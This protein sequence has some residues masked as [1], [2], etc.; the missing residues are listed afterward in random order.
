MPLGNVCEYICAH[1]CADL[2]PSMVT[3]KTPTKWSSRF[4]HAWCLLLS[5]RQHGIQG[6]IGALVLERFRFKS[7]LNHFL[8]VWPWARYLT[9]LSLIFLICAMG[10]L[11]LFSKTLRIGAGLVVQRLSLHVPL[12]WP[13]NRWLRSQV[14]TYALLVKLCGRRPTYKVE[15]D[16]HGC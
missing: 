4:F 13:G 9:C 16:G 8:T 14:W 5:K 7:Q 12:W 6:R 3:I 10:I 15:E 11:T 1:E 2:V